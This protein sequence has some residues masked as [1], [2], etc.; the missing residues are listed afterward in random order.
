MNYDGRGYL[1]RQ[2]CHYRI[3]RGFV[4]SLKSADAR[5]VIALKSDTPVFHD[6]HF[7]YHCIAYP[8]I[9]DLGG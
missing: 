2:R 9:L 8:G 7:V 5:A 6:L 1:D 4:S 3:V